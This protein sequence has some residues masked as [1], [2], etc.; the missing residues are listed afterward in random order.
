MT[1]HKGFI[2][3][4]INYINNIFVIYIVLNTKL[5]HFA[6]AVDKVHLDAFPSDVFKTIKIPNLITFIFEQSKPK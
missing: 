5:S 3:I 4:K 6:F 2:Q 1:L